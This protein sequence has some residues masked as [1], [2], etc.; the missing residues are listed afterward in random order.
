MVPIVMCE[1]VGLFVVQE[2]ETTVKVDHSPCP[3][4]AA[5]LTAPVASTPQSSL[6]V[7]EGPSGSDSKKKSNRCLTCRKKVGLTGMMLSNYE[8]KR[9]ECYKSTFYVI[10]L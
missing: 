2:E 6:V 8:F 1:N 9:S 5:G 3:S 7:A 4:A 10:V